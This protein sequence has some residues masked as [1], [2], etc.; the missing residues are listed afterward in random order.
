MYKVMK[1][2]PKFNVI[3]TVEEN[4]QTIN[5]YNT[6]VKYKNGEFNILE[7]PQNSYWAD[8]F[9]IN[10]DNKN[11]IFFEDYDFNNGKGHISYCKIDFIDGK[12]VQ[13]EANQIIKERF[14][15]SFPFLF[16]YDDKLYIIPESYQD[17]SLNIY[18][19]ISFPDKWSTKKKL[20][21]NINAVDTTLLYYLDKFWLFTSV[22]KTRTRRDETTNR[23][24]NIFFTDNL[25]SENWIPHPINSKKLYGNL[26][27]HGTGRGAGYIYK[28]LDDFYYRPIQLNENYY[29]ESIQIN[30]IILL[31]E[32]EFV[33]ELHEIIKTPFGI[34]T[35]H[36]TKTDE[37]TVMDIRHF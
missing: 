13:E 33:E 29:A 27:S 35:H 34:G 28:G 1:R 37:Y 8:P 16:E 6:I 36:I 24:L 9:I 3:N 23:Y 19:C 22:K 32:T 21:R 2:N 10:R 14:H 17:K 20:I 15:L 4:K 26:G 30:K 25:F 7:Q 5:E 31:N 12:L 18:E 11:Y